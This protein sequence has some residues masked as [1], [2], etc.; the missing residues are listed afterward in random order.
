MSMNRGFFRYSPYDAIVAFCGLLNLAFLLWTFLV[1]PTLSWWAIALAFVVLSWAYCWNLQCVSHNFIHNPF[2]TSVWLNRLFGVLETL[3]IGMPHQLYHH[4][5]LNHHAG[6]N[7]A[8]GTDGTTR[9]WSSIY[10]YGMG[11]APEAFWKYCLLSF[12]RVEVTPVLRV[13]IRHGRAHVLQ[14]LVETIA[15]AAFWA[16]ILAVNLRYFVFFYL[17]SFFLGW[18]LSYAEG[19][20]EHYGAQ[21]G[22]SFANSVSSY[23]WLYNFLWLNNGYHQEHH[24][25]PKTHWTRMKE[26]SARIRPWMEASRT[27]ILRGPHI[28]GLIED[29]LKHSATDAVE[30]SDA[31]ASRK[32]AA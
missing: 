27:R 12:F 15:L 29:Y 22:N 21:P 17:P 5:H 26:L 13:C 11:D 32:R 31:G 19:Y 16:T 7:D 28:T 10:R 8:K 24:W 2:F 3:C 30:R 4:Y 23:H 25:D 6:D 1:F 20:L 18:V 9:D 14:T